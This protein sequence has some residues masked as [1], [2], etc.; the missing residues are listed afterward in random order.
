M[1]LSHVD[2]K[3][4]ARMVDVADNDSL[5]HYCWRVD[6]IDGEGRVTRG[7]VQRFRVRHL[8]FPGA[9]GYGR[10]ARGGRG[11]RVIE[12]TNLN[13]SGPGSLRAAVEAEGPR[14]VVFNVSGLITLKSKLIVRGA[15]SYL[16][17]AGQTAPGKGICIRNWTFGSIGARDTIIRF[18][19]LSPT[20][21]SSI[22]AR[23]AG[24]STRLSALAARRISPCSER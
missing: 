24:R 12:V 2:E 20:T 6:E 4:R 7:E 15:D 1:T 5:L 11:G 9:E 18:V 13:D 14:T 22:T 3:G 21:A 23:S 8:A 10:H 16:T 19:R 17:V